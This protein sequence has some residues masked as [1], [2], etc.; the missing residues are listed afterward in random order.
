MAGTASLVMALDEKSRTVLILRY[1]EDRKLEEIAQ[2]CGENLNT[3]KARLY[4]AL[5]KL[6]LD[7]A[8]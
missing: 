1:F 8:G 6:R 5:K 7:L 4:R 3:I 2:I